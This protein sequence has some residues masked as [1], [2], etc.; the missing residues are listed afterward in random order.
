MFLG[1]GVL[2]ICSKFTLFP[3]NTYVGLPLKVPNFNVLK[4]ILT[5]K[6]AKKTQNL[7]GKYKR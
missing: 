6:Y 2:K 7:F 4:E 5:L 1:K 3:E